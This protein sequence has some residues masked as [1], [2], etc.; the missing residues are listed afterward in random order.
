MSSKS[1]SLIKI[2][3][4]DLI[5]RE[6]L[7]RV[8]SLMLFRDTDDEFMMLIQKLNQ[9][10]FWDLALWGDGDINRYKFILKMSTGWR[11]RGVPLDIIRDKLKANDEY[12]AI[13]ERVETQTIFFDKN[14]TMDT[15]KNKVK[16]Y[17]LYHFMTK[18]NT[19]V[20]DKFSNGGFVEEATFTD[21]LE[22]IEKLY[23]EI[24]FDY[25]STEAT[26]SDASRVESRFEERMKKITG[27]STNLVIP[28]GIDLLDACFQNGGVET[29][30]VHMFGAP[31][32]KGKT[33]FVTAMGAYAW[34]TGRNV[35]HITIENK[36][37]DIESLYDY[38]ILGISSDELNGII[39]RSAK[40]DEDAIKKYREIRSMLSETIRSKSNILEVKKFQ[41]YKVTAAMIE[42]F[43]KR[44]MGTSP[45]PDV[46]II[47]HLDIMMS[48]HGFIT[49]MFQKGE[50][51]AGEVKDLSE[52]YNFATYTPTQVNR[53]GVK[54]NRMNSTKDTNTLGGEDTSRSMAKNE[55]VDLYVTVNQNDKEV[56][57][58][59]MR[60]FVDKNR[61][62]ID[63]MIIPIHFDKG[64][65]A[66]RTLKRPEELLDYSDDIKQ[67]VE[68]L[69]SRLGKKVNLTDETTFNTISTIGSGTNM[70]TVN[71]NLYEASPVLPS[72][73]AP[74]HANVDIDNGH[75]KEE[76]HVDLPREEYAKAKPFLDK[77]W[78]VEISEVVN[79]FIDESG[80]ISVEVNDAVY[81]C[82]IEKIRK[83]VSRLN[84]ETHYNVSNHAVV[85]TV[86]ERL[87]LGYHKSTP[88]TLD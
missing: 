45:K 63:R 52:R 1:K 86:L 75:V 16:T 43:I 61:H 11:L 33:R 72:V 4:V 60:L 12:K 17:L 66:I 80:M 39:R 83:A 13:I 47:D 29:G 38:A 24:T 25:A 51:I 8:A 56:T 23:N 22:Q 59:R 58:N 36:R 46:V 26:Y 79:I 31:Y 88:T 3:G 78:T 32:G 55:L 27:Q 48:N 40:N 15:L 37:D 70:P 7:D 74:L 62:G 49:D 30:C 6:F 76:V 21:V 42:A 18:F 65:L 41:P 20:M 73:A 81:A 57:K 69:M 84:D 35:Y 14:E 87:N 53:G 9:N 64:T 34:Q 19:D 28:T 71:M 2:P 77:L 10:N 5:D 44:K 54:T 85:G 82:D 68:L 67:H 50:L